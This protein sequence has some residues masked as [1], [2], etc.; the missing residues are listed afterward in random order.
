MNSELPP[1]YPSY[2]EAVEAGPYAS[3]LAPTPS[4]EAL[5]TAPPIHRYGPG[6]LIS[7]CWLLGL[8]AGQILFTIVA[9][10]IIVGVN[11]AKGVPFDPTKLGESAWTN[12]LLIGAS[13]FATALVAL[14][15]AVVHA[16]KNPVE[17]LRLQLPHP[18]HWAFAILTVIPMSIVATEAAIIVGKLDGFSLKLLQESVKGIDSMPL[19]AML[20]FGCVFP[21]LFEELL[22]RGVM[23]RGMTERNGVWIGVTFA[24]IYFGV[25]HLVPAHAVSAAIMGVF[26]HL[27]F[28]YSRSFWVPVL[29]HFINNSLAFLT[30]RYDQFVPIPGY[31]T[32]LGD[33]SGSHVPAPLL[34]CGALAAI[35]LI[36]SW[37]YFRSP[38]PAA[39]K[40]P[41]AALSDAMSITADSP[42][43]SAVVA[44]LLIGGLLASQSLLWAV[45]ANSIER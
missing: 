1:Q 12:T 39:E 30:S 41:P 38:S 11:A 44:W 34:A 21:G 22:F 18:R 8:F 33:V 17:R 4:P 28:L 13:Q 3:P 25:A 36:G 29:I 42:T 43:R 24:S 19:A 9:V 10:A 40:Q 37:R 16:R 6:I 45:L 5:P 32:D 14:L 7:F 2:P 23:G 31:T 26:M 27:A 15:A 35:A 20:L